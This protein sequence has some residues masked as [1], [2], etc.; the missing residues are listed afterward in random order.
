M[1][2]KTTDYDAAIDAVIDRVGKTLVL[3]IPLGLG[4]P[5]GFVNALYD[6]VA[7]DTSLNLVIFTALTLNTPRAPGVGGAFIGPMV[8][9]TMAA[10]EDLKYAKAQQ[11]GELPA[12][13]TVREFFFQAGTQ[14]GKLVP[15]Q[16]YISSN[17]THVA[18]DMIDHGANVFAQ[19]VALEDRDGE[20]RVSLSCNPDVTL[21]VVPMARARWPVATV[22]VVEP[23]LPFMYGDADRPEAE[24]DVLLSPPARKAE[25][26]LFSV[27]K[28]PVSLQDHAIGLHASR[29]V[30]DGGTIQ[31]G[32]GA[33]G[34]SVSHALTLR[35]NDNAAYRA[36]CDNLPAV[37]ESLRDWG[38]DDSFDIG[39]YGATEMF[40][41]G[42][43]ALYNAGVL[44]RRVFDDT[45]LQAAIN[46]GD[47]TAPDAGGFVLHGGFFLGPRCF[48]DALNAM[49]ADERKLFNM[50]A[51][52]RINQLYSSEALDRLQRTE[53]RF[54]N[55]GLKCTLSGAVVSD[56]LDDHRVLSGVGGQYNFVAQAH[57]LDDGRSILLIKSVRGDG[58][59]AESNIVW[60]YPH[61]TIARHLRDIIIT[62]YG[63]AN[64]RGATDRDIIARLL[65]IADSRFQDSL[66]ARAKAAGKIEADYAIPP[67]YQNNT[68]AALDAALA[69]AQQAGQLPYFP[70]PSDW[71]PDEEVLAV[72]L[73]RLKDKQA[74]EGKRILWSA[75]QAGAPPAEATPYLSRV[76]LGAPSD[77]QAKV[78]ARLLGA[79]IAK[80]LRDEAKAFAPQPD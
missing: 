69:G 30:K 8:E 1:T 15:Q 39:L 55:T 9:R 23:E 29:L 56:A 70:L 50:T 49:G 22:G 72:A 7:D 61:T 57:A 79:E 32:I 59:D 52:K 40:V 24:F 2:L 34:D 4:K 68:P 46:T 12:N 18:R 21:E 17:Y 64:L 67:E 27:P 77:F 6:R 44:K 48:Y 42:F 14:I 33:L 75:W 38:G 58:A 66:L 65:N 45:E 43:L 53:A 80:L 11:R 54:I 26:H 36:I 3:G 73:G 62:E 25:G 35:H 74:R 10:Y 60:D 76:G 63:I 78:T 16:N 28:L 31:L 5:S 20:Q 41:D 37:P 19:L 51:V 47:Q 71:T 13:I